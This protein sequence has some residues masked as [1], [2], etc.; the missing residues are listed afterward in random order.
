MLQMHHPE[1]H[2]RRRVAS[3]A[4]RMPINT[5]GIVALKRCLHGESVVDRDGK[6]VT[7]DVQSGTIESISDTS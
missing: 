7:L 6:T 3:L 2:R 1:A 4:A 5:R